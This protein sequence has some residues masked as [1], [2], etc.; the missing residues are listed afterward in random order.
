MSDNYTVDNNTYATNP[1]NT[2]LNY[3]QWFLHNIPIVALLTLGL[4]MSAYLVEMFSMWFIILFLLLLAVNGF[5]WLRKKEHFKSGDS[6]GGIVVSV[7]PYLLAVSTDLTRGFG[8]FPIV[9]IVKIRSREKL[10]VGDKVPTVALY[11]PSEKDDLPHW[12]DFH[13]QPLFYASRDKIDIKR[14]MDSYSEEDWQKLEKRI[15]E[16]QKPYVEGIFKVEI[17]ESD[18]QDYPDSF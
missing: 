2:E 7:N 18:W 17:T 11:S 6:N 9:K 4:L 3:W 8:S 12:G 16:I 1:G 5:Y 14:A 13:P 10:K 15:G